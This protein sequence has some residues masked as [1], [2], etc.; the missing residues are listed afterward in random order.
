MSDLWRIRT[1]PDELLD[2]WGRFNRT[3]ERSP[4]AD[5]H[6]LSGMAA[7]RTERVGVFWPVCV[8]VETCAGF[9]ACR[10][11]LIHRS[12]LEQPVSAFSAIS[13]AFRIA[14]SEDGPSGWRQVQA[15]SRQQALEWLGW[16]D[17]ADRPDP[18]ICDTKIAKF[19]AALSTKCAAKP[20]VFEVVEADRRELT[21]GN[22]LEQLC[23]P[24]E[25]G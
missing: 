8:Y 3:V 10:P 7:P 16:S 15:T 14:P 19:W 5:L 22:K 24:N 18:E 2:A 20:R 23:L 25:I 6:R 1:D 12:A 4:I 21:P 13:S 17:L 11:A 9:W